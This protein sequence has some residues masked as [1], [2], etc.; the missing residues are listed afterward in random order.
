MT[1]MAAESTMSEKPEIEKKI[2]ALNKKL[3]Q[4]DGLKEKDASLLDDAAREKIDQEVQIRKEIK[5]LEAQLVGGASVTAPAAKQEP[6]VEAPP[7]QESVEEEEEQAELT[8]EEKEKKMKAI[9]KKLAQ[10]DK[11]KEKDPKTLDPEAK[12]KVASE[13][14][15]LADLDLL[16][17]KVRVPEVKAAAAGNGYVSAE[18]P[19]VGKDPHKKAREKALEA[20][21][22]DISIHIDEDTE[23]RFKALQKKLRDIGKLHEKDKL[24]KLQEEKLTA[25]PGLINEL[26][27]IKSKVQAEMKARREARQA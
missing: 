12:A 27:E 4:I 18:A 10:I 1:Y 19:V 20:P 8:P 24:D 5:M 23:K 21:P 9:K 7:A 14:S 2:R 11:L 13:A 17:G 15:L 26:V 16:E 6:V 25:E 3:K 22:G